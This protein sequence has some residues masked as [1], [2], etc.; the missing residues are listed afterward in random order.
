MRTAGFGFE[1]LATDAD[2]GG[3][4]GRLTT[5]HGTVETPVFIP[6]GTQA[7][8]KTLS[9]RDLEEEGVELVLC[10]TYHLSLRPGAE[11]IAALG[12]LHRFMAW[13]HPLL[14]DSGGY[15]VFSMAELRRI[16]E[17]GVT[18]RSHLDGSSHA[19]SPERAIAIQ[20]AL[21][22][23][24]IMAFDDCTSYPATADQAR[25]SLELTLRWAERCLK[26][27]TRS[28]QALFG[29]VQ[30]SV[31][32]ELREEA[33]ARLTGLPF[34]GYAIGGLSVGESKGQ[35]RAVLRVTAPRLPA[36]SPRYLMGIGTPE[37][38]LLGI[39]AGV[40]MFDCVMPTRHGR[41][42]SLFT[43]QG[44]LSIKAAEYARDERP[45]DPECGCYTCRS[46][47]RAYLRHLFVAD[48]T[49]GLRLNTLHNLH[50]YVTLMAEA[51]GALA[52]GTFAKFLDE[53]LAVL[54]G[55][56]DALADLD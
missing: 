5:P 4:R 43:R 50:F 24:I 33:A 39:A 14:T 30:G 10:N 1:V 56:P 44:R 40:D 25:A 41:T 52:E 34:D 13:P 12:G 15:Q 46:F 16:S 54:R 37:D 9:P 53:R 45:V 11:T 36:E 47:S 8:V 23:D 28:D 22:A 17:E 29:I 42:G 55:A 21:G 32:P 19:L 51:R 49:L 3:R 48:E 27:R 31:Y 2:T 20:E 18:F 35:M 38:L 7:T 26:A 6:C